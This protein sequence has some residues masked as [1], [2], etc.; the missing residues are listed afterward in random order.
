M[1]P[2]L[3]FVS[4]EEKVTKCATGVQVSSKAIGSPFSAIPFK[5][6]LSM[7]PLLHQSDLQRFQKNEGEMGLL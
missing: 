5:F 4:F 1:V 7:P 2:F 3:F 6:I